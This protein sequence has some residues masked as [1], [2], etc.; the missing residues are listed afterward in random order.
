MRQFHARR[1]LPE[2]EREIG[3]RHS[4]RFPISARFLPPAF[5]SSSRAFTSIGILRV[6]REERRP[7]AYSQDR[8]LMLQ[9]FAERVITLAEV[10][11]QYFSRGMHAARCYAMSANAPVEGWRSRI[12]LP[13]TAPLPSDNAAVKT[14]CRQDA[15]QYT[16]VTATTAHTPLIDR[17]R[18]PRQ[19]ARKCR[20]F[21]SAA[22]ES[23]TPPQSIRVFRV[24]MLQTAYT[25]Y[26]A[27]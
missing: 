18:R 20:F 27:G 7:T 14:D 4:W 11:E 24:A 3:E 21:S 22:I 17:Q 25:M 2:E 6:S 8:A 5:H 1:R 19:T 9:A 23:A 12:V 26:T 10:S 13:D 16:H 15:P